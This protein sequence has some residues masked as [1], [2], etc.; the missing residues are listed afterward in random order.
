MLV[1][2]NG[3]YVFLSARNPAMR[4]QATNVLP[5]AAMDKTVKMKL[6]IRVAQQRYQAGRRLVWYSPSRSGSARPHDAPYAARA[7]KMV[8]IR[9]IVHHIMSLT[10]L[11]CVIASSC[12]VLASTLRR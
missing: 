11:S 8:A 9:R 1:A 6:A 5:Q 10:P 2:S 4:Q 7:N 12:G 3:R